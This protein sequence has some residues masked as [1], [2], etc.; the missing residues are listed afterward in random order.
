MPAMI[1]FERTYMA[2][3]PFRTVGSSNGMR[4]DACIDSSMTAKLVLQH[5]ISRA[6]EPDEGFSLCTFED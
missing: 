6:H 3:M 5:I 4:L 1:R 2:R